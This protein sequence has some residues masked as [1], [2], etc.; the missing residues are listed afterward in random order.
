MNSIDITA[1]RI[2]ATKATRALLF[3]AGTVAFGW[4]S[5]WLASL[6]AT[7]KYSAL[8]GSVI[9]YGGYLL[10][11]I[12]FIVLFLLHWKD[13]IKTNLQSVAM[14]PPSDSTP[15]MSTGL[16]DSHGVEI[17][18]GDQIKK[19]VD[20]N[21]DVHGQWVIFKVI[22]R[23]LTPVLIYER[24]ASG[25]VMPKGMSGGPLCDEYEVEEFCLAEELHSIRPA[26]DLMVLSAQQ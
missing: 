21:Q 12:V 9:L 3:V 4:A 11:A 19:P 15:A 26:C 18:I 25:Y 16:M 23:G 10:L 2:L 6:V 17:F 22:Q 1:W 24:S 5:F 20:C 7:S 8:A 14:D 13:Q